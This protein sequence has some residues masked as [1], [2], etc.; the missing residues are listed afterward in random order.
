MTY[1]I[2]VQ[3]EQGYDIEVRRLQVAAQ[4][5]LEQHEIDA[6]SSMTIVIT[7][8]NAVRNLNKLHRRVDAPTDVLSFPADPLPP[9][10]AEEGAYLGDIIIAHDYALAQAQRLEHDFHES[11]ALLVIHGVLHLLGYDHVIAPQKAKMW[12]AQARALQALGLSEDLVPG[13]EGDGRA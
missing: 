7:G 4:T 5:V 1:Q 2:Q 10:L 9:E 3:N 6:G 8:N 12:A 11:L 13:L